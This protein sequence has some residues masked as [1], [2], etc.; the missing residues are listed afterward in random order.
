MIPASADG[1]VKLDVAAQI[2][3]DGTRESDGVA[4]LHAH[5]AAVRFIQDVDP[6]LSKQGEAGRQRVI[7]R[8]TNTGFPNMVAKM[9]RCSSES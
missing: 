3:D 6:G 9:I 2:S 5:I 1:V 7:Q 8:Q 4:P